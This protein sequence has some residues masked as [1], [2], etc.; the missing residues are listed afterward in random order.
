M[1]DQK[2]SALTAGDPAQSGDAI[3]IARGGSNFKITAGSIAALVTTGITVGSTT[4]SSGTTGRILYDNAGIVGERAITGTGSVVLATAP[5]LVGPVLLNETAGSSAIDITGATQ[6]TTNPVIHASQTWNGAGAFTAIS[7]IVT[8]NAST[9][10]SLLLDLQT[11]AGSKFSVG[12]AGSVTASGAF[13]KVTITPPATGSTLTIADGKVLTASNT[14]AFA[15]TDSSTLNIGTGGTL[16]T[17]AYTAA[18]AYLAAGATAVNSSLLLGATWA[19]PAAIGTGTPAAVTGTTITA[20][21]GFVGP[22]NG[23][24]GGGTPAAGTFTTVNKLTLTTPATGSTLT[25]LDG[26]TLTVSN[27]LTLAGTDSTTMTFPTT[28]ATLA[29]TDAGN[30]FTGNQ[31]LGDPANIV[32]GTVTGT[33][34]GTATTQKLAFFNSTPIV[35]PANTVAIDTALVNLG[36]RATGGVANFATVTTCPGTYGTIYVFDGVTAQTVATGTTPTLLTCWNTATGFNGVANDMTPAK[37]SNK[38]TVTRAGTYRVAYNL[39]YTCNT[40]LTTWEFYCFSGGAEAVNMG[41]RFTSAVGVNN[42]TVSAA[43]YFAIAANADID[44][45]AF[46]SLGGNSIIT[47]NHANLNIQYLGA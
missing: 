11:S 27:I 23:I 44:V 42:V 46:H 39:S 4:V 6:T 47:I 7:L 20:N 12:K 37:A 13:N 31:T 36:L 9:A 40:D 26:K 35:Q 17:A 22:L 18:T 34:I 19:A 1:P 16:G 43:G 41:T 38:I 15:G 10:A 8:D 45:R 25:I 24:V 33:K 30:T 5:T 2:I 14:L 3:P 29:R 28:S 21:T 32:L